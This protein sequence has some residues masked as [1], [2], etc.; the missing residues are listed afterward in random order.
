M[1]ERPLA[2]CLLAALAS[3]AQACSSSSGKDAGAD[4]GMEPV[5]SGI[6]DGGDGG[7]GGG[8]ATLGYPCDSETPCC[9]MID[10]MCDPLEGVCTMVLDGGDGGI[11]LPSDGAQWVE[12][13]VTAGVAALGGLAVPSPA[14]QLAVG[15]GPSLGQLL[16]RSP[17]GGWSVVAGA[18]PATALYGVWADSSGDVF[19]VGAQDGGLPLWLSGRLDGGLS[20]IDLGGLSTPDSG[21]LFS[22][23]NSVLGLGPAEALA[24][25]TAS[26]STPGA[27]LHLLPDGGLSVEDFP[28][29]YSKVYG[30]AGGADGGPI[31]ALALEASANQPPLV[32][33]RLAG[34]WTEPPICPASDP[35]HAHAVGGRSR[36]GSDRGWRRRERQWHRVYLQRRWLRGGPGASRRAA[37]HGS[38]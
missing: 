5:D 10:Q 1:K 23:L 32:L 11:P 27:A 28:F 19:A 20:S 22:S 4:A 36:W 6:E 30:L 25:G 13:T 2:F 26:H 34:A 7:G 16:L 9:D 8:C 31:Y 3:L 29:E 37:P 14:L 12:E 35:V 21:P 17:D 33:R 18:P 24:V 15:T 38:L